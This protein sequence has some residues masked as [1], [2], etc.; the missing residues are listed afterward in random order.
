[1]STMG[2]SAASSSTSSAR[3]ASAARSGASQVT[4]ESDTTATVAPV[5]GSRPRCPPAN[6]CPGRA[7]LPGRRPASTIA[8]RARRLPALSARPRSNLRGTACVPTSPSPPTSRTPG[9]SSTPRARS[10]GRIATEAATLLRGKHKP[11]WVPHLDVGDHVDRH[12]RRQ[13]RHQRRASSPTSATT[14]TR[15]TR[16]VCGEESLEHLLERDP[17]RVVRLAIR[18]MLPKGPLGRPDARASCASTPARP[19]PTRPSSRKPRPLAS[20]KR[21]G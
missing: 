13:A 3:S 11:I 10:S 12:E 7:A 14:A 15:V 4:P 18:G 20:A 1:M 8:R 5:T 6:P 19:I 17:E 9:T 2:S 21:A 16:A